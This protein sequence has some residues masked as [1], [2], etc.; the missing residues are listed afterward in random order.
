MKNTG[1]TVYISS[2]SGWTQKYSKGKDGWE[3]T[4]NGVVRKM[5]AEQLLS[6]LL[7]PL[8]A[9]SRLSVRVVKTKARK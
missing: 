9:G 6:H 1:C 3:Q 4:T 2:K 7:P 8:V 5:T